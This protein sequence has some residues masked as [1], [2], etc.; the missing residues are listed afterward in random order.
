MNRSI[1]L[2]L[3]FFS[4]Y[5]SSQI[6]DSVSKIIFTYTK[7][8]YTF[9]N[10]GKYSNTE[11]IEYSKI[12]D[13]VFKNSR[14]IRYQH[15]FVATTNDILTDTFH[16][17]KSPK[18][19]SL[20]DIIKVIEKLSESESN[21][22]EHFIIPH[23][24]KPSKKDVF[25]IAKKYRL[26]ALIKKYSV[27]EDRLNILKKMSRFNKLDTFLAINKPRLDEYFVVTDVWNR[28]WIQFVQTNDTISFRK[29]FYGP[30][31]QP[32]SKYQKGS[33]DGNR[34]FNLEAN[35]VIR[36]ILPSKSIIR[37]ILDLNNLKEDYIRWYLAQ[38]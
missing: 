1:F 22:N 9:G 19:I 3:I 16:I 25:Q 29:D 28:L 24:K 38:N 36:K 12:N 20:Y 30:L 23:L 33:E 8:H 27:K 10:S 5:A 34:T 6:K 13:S 26:T 7:G 15:A 35:I 11:V 14:Y 4:K 37:K 32:V 17:K 31:G 21:F 2:F 18:L